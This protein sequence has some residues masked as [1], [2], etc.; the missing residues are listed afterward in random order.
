M[1]IKTKTQKNKN[2]KVRVLPRF[3]FIF[4]VEFKGGGGIHGFHCAKIVTKKNDYK[5]TK[6]NECINF[7][8]AMQ[9]INIIVDLI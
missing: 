4:E 8:L 9:L 2:K 1:H 6:T 3:I 7:A 5:K